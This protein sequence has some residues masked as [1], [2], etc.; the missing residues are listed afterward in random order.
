M[1]FGVA[2]GNEWNMQMG[3]LDSNLIFFKRKWKIFFL[4]KSVRA[5][6]LGGAVNWIINI[7]LFQ[8]EWMKNAKIAFQTQRTGRITHVRSAGGR[9]VLSSA[10][11]FLSTWQ[12]CLYYNFF[13]A[14]ASFHS[15]LVVVVFFALGVIYS[16]TDTWLCRPLRENCTQHYFFNWKMLIEISVYFRTDA[17][18]ESKPWD[19]F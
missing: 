7:F 14:R 3:R 12:R 15:A 19:I 8:K 1:S 11:F 2:T 17:N 13:C 10:F 6:I 18:V 16:P 4:K 5:K 9:R